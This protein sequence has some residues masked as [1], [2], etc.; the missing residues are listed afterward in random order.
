LVGS[1]GMNGCIPLPS[2]AN[3]SNYVF[4]LM[5]KGTGA[6]CFIGG[7]F[8]TDFACTYAVNA[9]WVQMSVPASSSWTPAQQVVT[10]P[11]GTNSVHV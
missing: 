6:N 11:A 9:D 4:G 10:P 2:T 5:G 1:N 8:A 7:N 3:G